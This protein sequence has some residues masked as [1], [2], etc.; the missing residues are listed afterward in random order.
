[1]GIKR[2]GKLT[3]LYQNHCMQLFLTQCLN[4]YKV[5]RTQSISTHQRTCL[6]FGAAW[7]VW[8]GLSI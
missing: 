2:E 6:T 8:S 4:K 3:S 1:M 5:V 7:S